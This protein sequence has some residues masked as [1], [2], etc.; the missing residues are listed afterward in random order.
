MNRTKWNAVASLTGAVCLLATSGAFAGVDITAEW[1]FPG[2][3]HAYSGMGATRSEAI[4]D[5]RHKCIQEN[6]NPEWIQVCFQ[7]PTISGNGAEPAAMAKTTSS[8][9]AAMS[10][11]EGYNIHVQ[12]P[13]LMADGTIAGPFHHYCKP[14]SE[15]VLQCLLFGST[16]PKA[17]LVAIEYFVAKTVSRKE[18][19]L[20]KWHRNFHDH[21]VEI[22]TGR[23]KV[24][25]Q[26]PDKAAAIAEAAS[27]T[28]GIIFHL[29]HDDQVI[30]DGKV[31]IPQSLGHIFTR[32]DD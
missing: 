32:S 25:D 1:E 16:A 13:H 22:A 7:Q 21:K 9:E 23:V 14:I 18:V 20:I 3:K 26:P 24:L 15:E 27:K 31:T 11:A 5:A 19:P 2:G 4:G 12:A 29:W 30:P 6:R 8:G 28:D 10:P 17:K